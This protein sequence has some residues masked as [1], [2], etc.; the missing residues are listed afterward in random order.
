M[1]L[2]L[3]ACVL[4][5]EV[6]R[7]VLLD[8][9]AADGFEP[10]WSSRILG[11]WQTAVVRQ[12][13]PAEAALVAGAAA[14]MARRFPDALVTGWEELEDPAGLPDPAD[15]HVIAA[16]R[17]G[18]ADGIVTLNIRDFPLRAMAAAGLARLHADAFLVQEYAAGG[19]LDAV[20]DAVEAA[21][22]PEARG[23]GFRGYL[24][25]GGLPRLAK[26]HQRARG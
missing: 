8:Y 13:G 23:A 18:G 5:P 9:A 14:A 17:A 25:R 10:L 21:A 1:R 12:R 24:K 7:R 6:M 3:D 26:A 4:F 22:P 11:E 20:L 2:V 16:G 19:A 15:A